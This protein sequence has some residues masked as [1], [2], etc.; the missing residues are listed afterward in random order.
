MLVGGICGDC[1]VDEA[2]LEEL[3]TDDDGAVAASGFALK[4]LNE[5]N[6]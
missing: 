2:A 4:F 6:A 5:P 1:F 3:I